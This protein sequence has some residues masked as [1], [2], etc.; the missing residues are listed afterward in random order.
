MTRREYS[1]YQK[2]VIGRYYDNQ[3]AVMLQRLQELVA[4]LYLANTDR[5]RAQ[6][7]K[8]AEAAMK[9]LRVPDSV[10]QHILTQQRP[11]VLAANLNDWLKAA[12][13][14]SKP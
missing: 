13:F 1:D 12:D 7:W 5:K 9:G 2:K 14:N 4:E 6:L 3:P 8:R 11:E 10:M